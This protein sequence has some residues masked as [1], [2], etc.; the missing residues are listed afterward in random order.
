MSVH[1]VSG[2][3]DIALIVGAVGDKTLTVTLKASATHVLLKNL[4]HQQGLMY[5]LG[6]YPPP[7]PPATL[8]PDF[9]ADW[10]KLDPR[11]EVEFPTGSFTALFL[12]KLK[13]I[14]GTNATHDVSVRV[15]VGETAQAV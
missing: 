13:F 10:S 1:L 7:V 12:R 15:Q 6:P 9:P 14:R 11:K 2:Q 3:D 5:S 8:R 4:D